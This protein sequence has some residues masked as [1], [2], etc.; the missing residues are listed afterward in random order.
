MLRDM[1]FFHKA[2]YNNATLQVAE[3]HIIGKITIGL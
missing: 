3:L 1:L 2:K